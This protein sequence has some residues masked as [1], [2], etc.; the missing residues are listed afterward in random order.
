MSAWRIAARGWR[1][2]VPVVVVNA[3]VQAATVA[4]AFTP[5]PG[6]VFVTLTVLSFAVLSA[7]LGATASAADASTAGSSMTFPHWSVWAAS[8]LAVLG[9][10]ASALLSPLAVPFAVVVAL[11]VLPGIAAGR[12]SAL[13]GFRIFARRPAHA[14]LLTVGSFVTLAILWVAGLLLGFFVTGPAAA[15]ATWLVFGAAAVVLVCAWTALQARAGAGSEP[16]RA[17]YAE[18]GGR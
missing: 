14:V 12:R 13:A 7:A 16:A 17:G 1:V 9:V 4:P 15:F 5:E 18:L 3:V 10:T 2:F 11:V 8:A 6:A